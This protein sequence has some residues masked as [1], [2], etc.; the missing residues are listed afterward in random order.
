M[1]MIKTSVQSIWHGEE[2]KIQGKKVTGKTCF[3]IGLVIEGQAKLLCPIDM[4]YLAASITVAS[5]SKSTEMSAVKANPSKAKSTRNSHEAFFSD[6]P[7]NFRKITPPRDE[8][9][10]FVGTVV[11]YGPYIEFG[12]V[13]SAA[14]P[15]LRPSLALAKGKVLTLTK[16]NAKFYFK[17]YLN[18]Y[19]NRTSSY[20]SATGF[21]LK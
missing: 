21:V 5:I 1:S 18:E 4:G 6:M 8:E 11:E 9:E 16:F 12:T 15:F 14:Q 7:E 3:E 10:V 20:S 13:K 2:I 17:E 19:S